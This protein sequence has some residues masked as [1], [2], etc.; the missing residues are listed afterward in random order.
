MQVNTLPNS[1]LK[2]SLELKSKG[3][4]SGKITF[5]PVGFGFFHPNPQQEHPKNT[6]TL[7][8]H[9]NNIETQAFH[10]GLSKKLRN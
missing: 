1:H 8:Q 4:S 5:T 10:Q 9:Y 7:Q 2:S 6:T 3:Y